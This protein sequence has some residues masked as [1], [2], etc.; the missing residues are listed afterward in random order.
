MGSTAPEVLHQTI[1]LSRGKHGSPRSGVC[2]MEL[3][4]MLAG[5]R[6]TDQPASACPVIGGFMRAY[7]D[8][9]DDRRRQDLLPYAAAVVGSRGDDELAERRAAAC[10]RFA[11]R[12]R[13]PRTRIGQWLAARRPATAMIGRPAVDS[14]GV[15][16]ARALRKIDDAGHREALAFIDELLAI[17]G[18]EPVEVGVLREQEAICGGGSL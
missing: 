6:F 13:V 15:L 14:A 9:A 1:R 16:A 10:L 18:K 5:E 17:Q 8:A 4:S 12:V 7:N 3:A 2:V 11:Q